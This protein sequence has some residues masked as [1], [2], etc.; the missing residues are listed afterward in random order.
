MAWT[1]GN[2]PA[3]SVL[4]SVRLSI[5]DI[6]TTDQLITDEAINWSLSVSSNNALR[7]GA[8]CCK[9]IA[10]FFARQVNSSIDTYNI[11]ASQKY[12]QYL[13]MATILEEQAK[14]QGANAFGI[15]YVGGI[16]VDE[17]NTVRMD[18]ARLRSMF[19]VGQFTNPGSDSNESIVS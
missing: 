5:G 6:D 14:K 7:A 19:F 8:F 16:S 4:D 10:A 12:S 18:D 9:M 13:A 15:P 3:V 11:Q 17:I 2:N 1:F